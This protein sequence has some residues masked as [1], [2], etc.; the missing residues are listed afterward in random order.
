MALKVKLVKSSAGASENQL[1]T[2]KGLGLRKFGQERVL[3]D[4][5]SIRGMAF[6][7]QHLVH[8]ETVSEQAPSRPRKKPR[9]IVQRD[10]ALAKKT[11]QTRG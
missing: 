6:K 8:A 4:T 11:Q 7:V 2:L 10:Q 1:R 9:K 3:Q 5:P